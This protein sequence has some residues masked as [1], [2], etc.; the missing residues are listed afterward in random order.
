[1]S[2]SRREGFTLVE[3]LVVIAIIGVLV[4]LLLPAV[5]AAREAAR[6]SSCSN[7]LKQLAIGCHN[8]HDVT[9]S[10]PMNYGTTPGN[11][12]G[13]DPPNTLHRST[14]WMV[15]V[16][17]FI[18]QKPLY[19][20]I[21]FNF[22]VKLDPRNGGTVNNPN[23]PSNAFVARTVIPGYLCPSD[24]LNNKGRL[25]SRANRSGG[26][27]EFAVNNYKGVC[28]ANWGS[29]NFATVTPPANST[30]I[31]FNV[32]QWSNNHND[33]LDGGNGIFFR[34]GRADIG[35]HSAT[36]M[37]AISDGT[38]NTLMIGECVPRWC[39]HTWWWWF[40]GTTATTAVPLNVKAQHS[41]C[42]T[43]NRTAD[44]NCAWGDWPNNYS[45]M[46]QHPGGAQFSLADGSTRFISQTIDL[47]IYRSLGTK[48]NGEA[49][50]L[51]N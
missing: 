13:A 10:F 49:V 23:N 33:G 41:N 9:N 44:L 7:N 28:G 39:T 46:S 50:Q 32:T 14:S 34:G 30:A 24:G 42:Q 17:P 26:G 22:D 4:A 1:M 40:N 2:R 12:H 3:L 5:Q 47:T 6:R 16:L 36:P 29:G 11:A 20:M 43:G 38:S 48:A 8:Y 19:D 15:Q 21:D 18:E 37:A 31:N 25:G 51:P 45:F 35:R 27:W